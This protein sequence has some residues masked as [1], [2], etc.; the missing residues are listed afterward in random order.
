M[1]SAEKGKYVGKCKR[2][3]LLIDKYFKIKFK[4]T[5]FKKKKKSLDKVIYI[6]VILSCLI[7]TL[8][9]TTVSE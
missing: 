4:S 3:C 2:Q 9:S 5:K 1:K 6:G 7:P 8:P